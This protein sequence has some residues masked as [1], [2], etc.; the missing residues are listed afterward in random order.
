MWCYTICHFNLFFK[1][2]VVFPVLVF[3]VC[4]CESGVC[5]Y[6]VVPCVSQH[7][8]YC[9]DLGNRK[10]LLSV[11]IQSW[12][13]DS[14][15]LFRR[16]GI[17][18]WNPVYSRIWYVCCSWLKSTGSCAL[19]ASTVLYVSPQLYTFVCSGGKVV[20]KP[21]TMSIWCSENTSELTLIVVKY[22]LY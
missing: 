19:C 10:S 12:A 11:D 22:N 16:A 14:L 8:H 20:Q 13:A 18:Q 7:H 15:S 9:H 1:S 2:V 5:A 3:Y 6:A 21:N 17:R 4:S